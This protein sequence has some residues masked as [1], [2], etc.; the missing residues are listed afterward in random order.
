MKSNVYHL[1]ARVHAPRA[2]KNTQDVYEDV[3][4]DDLFD[5][6]LDWPSRP[7]QQTMPK[8]TKNILILLTVITWLLL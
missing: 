7:E 8:A 5:S 1:P 2:A 6:R 4:I 3:A